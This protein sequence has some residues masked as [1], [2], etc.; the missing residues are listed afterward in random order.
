MAAASVA[1]DLT[2]MSRPSRIRGVSARLSR[3]MVLLAEAVQVVVRP[4]YIEQLLAEIAAPEIDAQLRQTEADLKTAEANSQLAQSTAVRWKFLLKTD[5][6]S[7]QE[8]DEKLADAKAKADADARA[9]AEAS[10][11]L[12]AVDLPLI[13]A[14]PY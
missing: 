7:K 13:A 12:C 11:T 5:S 14:S 4:S 9:K 1:R 3:A 2:S 10:T 8:T 6:V